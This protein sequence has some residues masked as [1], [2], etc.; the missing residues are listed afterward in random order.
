VI[1][2]KSQASSEW[3]DTW[4]WTKIFDLDGSIP[5]GAK[6]KQIE[7]ERTSTVGIDMVW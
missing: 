4:D 6:N 7:L 2:F 3:A 1:Q 5:V